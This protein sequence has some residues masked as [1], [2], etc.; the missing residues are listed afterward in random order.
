MEL[1][2]AEDISTVLEDAM[3]EAVDPK[4]KSILFNMLQELN[5]SPLA[6]ITPDLSGPFKDDS[7]SNS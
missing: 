7:G 5:K 1:V 6:G 4:K 2:K 3:H